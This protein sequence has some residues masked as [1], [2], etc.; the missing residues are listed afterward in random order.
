MKIARGLLG[1]V[2]LAASVGTAPAAIQFVPGGSLWGLGYGFG[3]VAAG[4]PLV[5]GGGPTGSYYGSQQP[6]AYTY[7]FGLT[8]STTP[9]LT[10]DYE[11]NNTGVAAGTSLQL[12]FSGVTTRPDYIAY[13]GGDLL[14]YQYNSTAGT[15][16]MTVS[17]VNPTAS[18]LDPLGTTLNSSFGM[19]IVTGS[20]MDF[21]GTVFQTNMFWQDVQELASYSGTSFVA[22]LNAY[23]V[24]SGL[25]EFTA[26][27]PMSF[28]GANGI[29]SP[30]DCNAALQKDGVAAVN[31]DNLTRVIY[32][33]SNP[34]FADE[35]TLWTYGGASG[36]NLD[37]TAGNDDYVKATYSN[38]SWSQGNIGIVMIPEPASWLLSL[39]ASVLLIVRR[40]RRN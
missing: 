2:I 40:R 31:L 1:F 22:G 33:D 10:Y 29:T 30:Q 16:T 5:D 9:S 36:L 39:V 17:T 32:T 24:A 19:K 21:G 15:L 14:A 7:V 6:D 38:D 34:G 26:Y 37:G 8:S 18:N 13:T 11:L 28:L 20:G 23:G 35:G 4:G 3:G 12:S 25:A 27:L